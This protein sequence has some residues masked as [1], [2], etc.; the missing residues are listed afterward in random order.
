[1]TIVLLSHTLSGILKFGDT[2][3]KNYMA[4]SCVAAHWLR[5]IGLS[6][7]ATVVFSVR[8]LHAVAFSK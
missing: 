7:V 8:L 3:E 1:M 6:C 5:N 2:P 4:N